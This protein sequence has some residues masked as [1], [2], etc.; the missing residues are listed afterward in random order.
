MSVCPIVAFFVFLRKLEM[1]NEMRIVPLIIIIA[2]TIGSVAINAGNTLDNRS[3]AIVEAHNAKNKTTRHLPNPKDVKN[4]TAEEV[5]DSI[6]Y[7]A[8]MK[9]S[10]DSVLDDLTSLG[11]IIHRQREELLLAW[12]PLSNL[13]TI[14][15]LPLIN[16]VSL[17]S[18]MSI[19]LDKA[20]TMSR[21]DAVHSAL[22]L[23]QAFGGEGVVV[24]IS[25]VG[26][27]PSHPAFNNDR[28][29]R[30]VH[31]DDLH[32][33]RYEMTG[34]DEIATW[35]TDNAKEWHA[36][37]VAGILSGGYAGNQYYGVARD[38][39][40][41]ITTSNLY[42]MSILA[43]VEDVVD[44]ARNVGKP[45]VVNMSVGYNL[46]PHDGTSLFNQY[47]EKV[48]EE[49]ILCLSA[50]N[51]GYKMNY[52]S[53]DVENEGDELKTFVYNN[54]YYDGITMN[55]AIDLWSSD[56]RDFDVALTIYDRDSKQIVYTSPFVSVSDGS[57][58]SWG[59]ASSTQATVNDITI[60]LFEN[61]LTGSVRIYSSLN[62]ENNRFNSYATINV[63]NSQLDSETG[64]LG[65]YCIGFVARGEPGMH[66]DVYADGSGVVLHSL[67]VD[68]FTHGTSARSISDLAC[69]RN[70]IAVG[71]SNSR[72]ITPQVNGTDVTYNFNEGQVANFSSY[73]TL[74]DGRQLPHFCAPG[75]MIVSPISS[76]YVD[77]MS[78]EAREGL[79]AKTTIDGKDYYWVSECGTSM[80][81]PYTAGVIACWL[82][83]DSSLTVD[84]VIEIA[85]STAQTDFSDIADPRWGAGNLD[86]HSGLLKVLERAGV[87]NVLIDNECR[88]IL[89]NDGDKRFIVEVPQC[90][91]NAVELYSVAG[92][93][94]YVSHGSIIDASASPAGV[95][96]IRVKH[97]KGESVQRVLIK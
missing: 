53:Y 51:E 44:Y 31:Y 32:A 11:V 50:G 91:I 75:N 82:Q 92:Q 67:S 16:A 43:G 37:H 79:A 84:D 9:I 39:D 7:P 59:V 26:F 57:S 55:G 83:A 17:S 19:T 30:V 87:G 22:Q 36:C 15:T 68:G 12:L 94:I 77:N 24:G 64:V 3:R 45:A 20:R 4:V 65:R 38:A 63:T 58:A 85:Q 90:E 6:Y 27:D 13:D 66:I 61:E 76:H 21:V 74:D 80:S 62:L 60:P 42:D 1:Y 54:I 73:G 14:A 97:S 72:N 40:M 23:P 78:D 46:G 70:V 81:S 28:L 18:P 2:L 8:I 96:I 56:Y 88:L 41:V 49:A 25:D 48:G 69:G 52:I 71:A 35:T 29:K 5:A 10:N 89:T 95:Y 47:L 93:K 33:K 86:A 34:A